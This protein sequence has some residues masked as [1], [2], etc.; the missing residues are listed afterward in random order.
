MRFRRISTGQKRGFRLGSGLPMIARSI[1]VSLLSA[2]L[3]PGATAL[4]DL[5][6]YTQGM[7]ALDSRLWEIAESRFEEALKTPD[8]TAADQRILRLK[9]LETWIRGDRSAEAMARLNE[10]TWENDPETYFWKAQALAGLGRYREAAEAL[11]PAISNDKAAHRSEALLTRASLQL[12]LNE[13]DAAFETLE[14]LTKVGE[15][16]SVRQAR[17]RQAAILIDQGKSKEPRKILPDAKS[18]P[19]EDQPEQA[20][21]H[22][23]LLLAEGKSAEAVSAFSILLDQPQ[24]QSL[25]R[26]H[27]AIVGLA[28]ALAASE[29][30]AA[31]ADSLLAAVQKHPDSPL[32]EA[33]FRRLQQW[34]PDQP[35]PND[36][37]LERLAQWSPASQTPPTGLIPT[38]GSGATGAW[39]TAEKKEG[40]DLNAFALF[41][42]A[43]GLHRQP[44]PTAKAEAVRLLTRLRIEH[45]DHFLAAKALMQ[46]GKWLL[47]EGHADRALS[48]LSAVRQN[49]GS[50]LI[51]GESAFI[52]ARAEFDRGNPAAAAALF[53][54]AA[55]LLPAGNGDLAALNSAL[56]RLQSGPVIAAAPSNP[57]RDARI[58]ADLE[59]ER[60]LS[61]P[62]AESSFAALRKFIS[63]HPQSK[64]I[65]EARLAA[66]EAGIAGY[67]AD[68]EFALEQIRTITSDPGMKAAVPVERLELARLHIADQSPQPSEAIEL[69]RQFLAEHGNSPEAAD[70]SM[71]LGR[72][73]FR[74]KDYHDA[75]LVLEKLAASA[76][77][78]RRA[79][80]ALM[81]AAQAAALGATAQSLE[82]SLILFGNV[83]SGSSGLAPL[84]RLQRASL[85]TKLY[86]FDATISELQPWFKSMATNDPLRIPAGR[87]LAQALFAQGGTKPGAYKEALS[88]YDQLLVSAAG[89]PSLLDQLRYL[90]G[91][92]LELLPR[93]DGAPGKRTREALETYYAVL[94]SAAIKPPTDWED[95]ELCGFRAVKLLEEAGRWE[96]AISTA[97]KIASFKGPRAEEAAA[98]AKQL[99][100][101]HMIWEE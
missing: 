45:P 76:P 13:Q 72:S 92:T 12:S 69:S 91:M 46:W 25:L 40:S 1:L 101:E 64:R 87:Q 36:A 47:E 38:I 99:R 42:R 67:P 15:A 4:K 51:Q 73:L 2:S 24:G 32:L 77:D 86:R 29:G 83:A 55:S 68:L 49:A 78:D 82:E 7:E 3:L 34:I 65:A 100:L 31:A 95:C 57:E 52:E 61:D 23:R 74:N 62:V 96:A 30:T 41:T 18:L 50:P 43:I 88:I 8:L 26:Y 98:R 81:L 11:A 75:R 71:I 35:A 39:P 93:T 85:L 10:A 94:Q 90:R 22:A 54:Q 20:F 9:Q 79:P 84:A 60:A 80:A 89:Q 21:L 27:S 33:I 44:T 16:K 14:V 28:D 5:A 66:A 17:L 58:Q 59:L 37:I 53:E 97:N 6:A 63:N 56:I 48:A 19:A 70:A